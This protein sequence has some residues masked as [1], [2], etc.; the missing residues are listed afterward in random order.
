[1]YGLAEQ[2]G[3]FK[4]QIVVST[5]ASLFFVH[6]NDPSM[7]CVR[8]MG[9]F[10]THSSTRFVA[11]EFQRFLLLPSARSNQND[12]IDKTTVDFGNQT[13]QSGY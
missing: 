7:L 5:P 6:P 12:Y 1:M 2:N 9:A 8:C 3:Y 4:S 10:R 13:A 11:G